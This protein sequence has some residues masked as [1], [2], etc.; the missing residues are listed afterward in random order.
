MAIDI[1]ALFRAAGT[2]SAR[3]V[4]T[5][6][7]PDPFDRFSKRLTPEEKAAIKVH[8][9]RLAAERAAARLAEAA[10]DAEDARRLFEG[11]DYAGAAAAA[12]RARAG[13]YPANQL[14]DFSRR[15][16]QETGSG[17]QAATAA[18]I[19]TWAWVVGGVAV[20]GVAVWLGRK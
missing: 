16:G 7:A 19:P 20:V 8:E 9:A 3:T 11:G 10:A 17:G 18:G 4:V 6:Y 14:P 15:P 2:G 5:K 13:G 12:A 1:E